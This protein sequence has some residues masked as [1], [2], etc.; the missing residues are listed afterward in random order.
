MMTEHMASPEA[1]SEETLV[2]PAPQSM[3]TAC[4]L[5]QTASARELV[6]ERIPLD[7]AE[8]PRLLTGQSRDVVAFEWHPATGELHYRT[9]ASTRMFG[10]LERFAQVSSH[11]A[12]SCG[13]R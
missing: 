10:D 13:S 7:A 2:P 4:G 6:F 11:S 12:L 3:A 1:A 8:T 9:T 5:E